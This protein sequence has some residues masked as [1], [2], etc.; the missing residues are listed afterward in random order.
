MD[1]FTRWRNARSDRITSDDGGAIVEFLGVTVV[2]LVPLIYLIVAFAHIQ[3]ASFAVESTARTAARTAA[4][5]GVQQTTA[6]AAT[7]EAMNHVQTSANAAA[8]LS[9]ENFSVDHISVDL[10]CEGECL[11]PGTAIVASA[12]ATVRLPG[13]PDALAA[14]VPLEV[15]VS[16]TG[17]SPVG[18]R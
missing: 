12:A 11:A 8:A 10:S 14:V 16:A 15:E 9:A 13:V 4:V 2:I 17:V 1:R 3:S 6:G 5:S 7:S 18:E